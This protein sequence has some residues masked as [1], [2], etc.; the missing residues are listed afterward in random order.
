VRPAFFP[1]FPLV[2]R[3]A[4]ANAKGMCVVNYFLFVIGLIILIYSLVSG[5]NKRFA[6]FL[7]CLAFP[8]VIFY[9]IPYTEATFLLCG[10]LFAL[11]LMKRNYVLFF[12]GLASMAMVR[13][14]TAFVW[15]GMLLI[16]FVWLALSGNKKEYL[17]DMLKR[18]APFFFRIFC[19]S[20]Y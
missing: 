18:S 6:L 9:I 12:I 7:M 17:W 15:M 3:V 19:F 11:G 2:W 16:D 14:A 4:G 13:P 1:L 5:E 20:S 8:Q 10:S